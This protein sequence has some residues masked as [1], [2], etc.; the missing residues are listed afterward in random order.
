M[1]LYNDRP[2]TT[3]EDIS[4]MKEVRDRIR[5]DLRRKAKQ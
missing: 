5:A 3:A 2:G 1:V 4:L